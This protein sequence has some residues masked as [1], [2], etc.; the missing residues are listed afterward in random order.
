M[1]LGLCCQWV[2]AHGKNTLVTKSLQLGRFKKGEYTADKIA[3]TYEAT[4]NTLEEHL[5]EKIIPSGIKSFRVSSNLFPLFDLVPNELVFSKANLTKLARIGDIVLDANMRF[6]MHPDQYV[7]LS[8]S[9][10]IAS[11]AVKELNFHSS[12]F[13]AMGL[14]QSPYYTINVHAGGS[15]S[16]ERANTLR[17]SLDKLTVGARNRLTLENC[18]FG[19]S[20]VDLT[21]FDVPICFDSHHHRFND[22]GI[23]CERALH[24][25]V[26][27]WPRGIKPLTHL[28]NSKPELSED[29][30]AAKLR[31]HS[32]FIGYIPTCQ[33]I[34]HEVG[35]IDI[36]VEA[37]AKNHAILRMVEDL[38]VSL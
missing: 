11:R 31:T 4:L 3:K 34:F 12:V 18:E 19:W 35:L 6:T 27:T 17:S 25:A 14:P 23:S 32:D 15:A 33:L 7:V 9:P 38:G 30:T 13:D 10:D 36:D 24:K 1:S 20:I 5:V 29:A 16:V 22:G 37:K 8:G 21:Q 2:D 26:M 28:S